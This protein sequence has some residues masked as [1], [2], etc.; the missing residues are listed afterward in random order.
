[1]VKLISGRIENGHVVPETPLPNSAEVRSVAVLL[2]LEE[3]PPIAPE[4]ST[5]ELLHG[6]AKGFEGDA[7]AAYVDYLIEKYR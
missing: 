3:P 5:F 2:E 6:I 4:K 7:Q 1:M